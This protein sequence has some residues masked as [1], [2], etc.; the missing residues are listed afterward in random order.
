MMS[1]TRNQS[2]T[3]VAPRTPATM[4]S[5]AIVWRM[6]VL[7]LP[8]YVYIL[9]GQTARALIS[10]SRGVGESGHLWSDEPL[11]C[12]LDTMDATDRVRSP[13]TVEVANNGRHPSVTAARA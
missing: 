12:T 10:F 7:Q 8:V 5:R 4:P 11:S 3:A 1:R 9:S 6:T 2:A 13:R